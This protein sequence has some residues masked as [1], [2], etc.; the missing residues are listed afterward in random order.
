M[1]DHP[2]YLFFRVS[3]ASWCCQETCLLNESQSPFCLLHRLFLLN[4]KRTGL[5]SVCAFKSKQQ[6]SCAFQLRDILPPQASLRMLK[7][8]LCIGIASAEVFINL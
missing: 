4:Y 5:A 8:I 3:A 7:T 2:V 6:G 1:L